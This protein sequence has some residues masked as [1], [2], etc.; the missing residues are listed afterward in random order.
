MLDSGGGDG[1]H[2]FKDEEGVSD[3]DGLTI[4][5]FSSEGVGADKVLSEIDFPFLVFVVGSQGFVGT[6]GKQS[7]GGLGGGG[8]SSF[9]ID[10][11][12]LAARA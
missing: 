4:S 7:V 12:Y 2:H 3:F 8:S 6:E 10:S 5:W 11:G 9:L 1:W